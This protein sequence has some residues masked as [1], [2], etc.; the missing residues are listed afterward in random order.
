MSS[1]Q[2][3]RVCIALTTSPSSPAELALATVRNVSLRIRP[4]TH[5]EPEP[6]AKP[7]LVKGLPPLTDDTAVYNLFRP[8]GAI[9]RVQCIE[10][11][12]QGHYTGFKGMANVVYYNEADAI[13]VSASG[14]APSKQYLY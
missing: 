5:R 7:R 12:L 3:A 6:A 10:T 2:A 14:Y 13:K 8:F 1:K 4:V 9:A 11:N